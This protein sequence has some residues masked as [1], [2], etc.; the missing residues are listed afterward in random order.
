MFKIRT[1]KKKSEAASAPKRAKAGANNK[2]PAKAR[3]KGAAEGKA[4]KGA[5]PKPLAKPLPKAAA[6]RGGSAREGK[7]G[8]GAATTARKDLVLRK[9]T[10]GPRIDLG[11]G[12]HSVEPA[13]GTPPSSGLLAAK[14]AIDKKATD[15]VLLDVREVSGL[16]DE[17]L[18]VTARSVPHLQSVAD[19]V[20]EALRKAGERV[21][22]R[23]GLAGAE[24]DWVLLDYGDLMVHV[25]RP[26][27]RESYALE[28]Y[29]AEARLVAR[30]KND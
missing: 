29:Y 18:V 14:A 20:E 10:P 27:S 17:M 9:R 24:P 6:V 15:V 11:V 23:D 13:P 21:V 7:R 3:A 8:K 19:A 26:E 30:W 5:L 28:A 2:K 4:R 16:C 22:H 1:A 25:F 12:P